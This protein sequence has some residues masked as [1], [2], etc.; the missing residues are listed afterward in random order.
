LDEEMR[1]PRRPIARDWR[2]D[3]PAPPLPGEEQ[4]Q[5]YQHQGG[6]K[7]MP[8]A[9]SRPGM[10]AQIERPELRIAADAA[11]LHLFR[12][13]LPRRS[14]MRDR[15]VARRGNRLAIAPDRARLV[16]RRPWLPGGLAL[17]QFL[18][19]QLDRDRAL[20][21]IDLDD[22]AVL[23]QGDRPAGRGFRRDV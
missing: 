17:G 21:G 15:A 18:I 3:Q 1:E 6:A 5:R 2:Y 20:V 19:G 4:A 11:A 14:R 9:R 16:L 13:F 22:V 7:E 12:R 10:F 23:Q 8:G